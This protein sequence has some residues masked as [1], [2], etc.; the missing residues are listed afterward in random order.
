MKK[1]VYNARYGGFGLSSDALYLMYKYGGPLKQIDFSEDDLKGCKK[2]SDSVFSY[3]DDIVILTDSGY[4]M[5]WFDPYNVT[6]RSHPILIKVV[7]ELGL[8]KASGPCAKLSIDVI[9]DSALYT[10]S[11]YDGYESVELML[12]HSYVLGF[13][14]EN[15]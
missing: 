5:F 6:N 11:E 13:V 1:V 9:P 2:I 12:N 7:E 3:G 8:E 4:K 14:M 15:N 10:I